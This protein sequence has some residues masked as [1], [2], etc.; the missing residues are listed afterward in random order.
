MPGPTGYI[1][2][3]Q[4][5]DDIMRQNESPVFRSVARAAVD[6]GRGQMRLLHEHVRR[7]AGSDLHM[8]QAIGDCVAFGAAKAVMTRFAVEGKWLG[9]IATESVYGFSRVEVGKRKLGHG[10][11][12]IGLWAV[13]AM[14]RF[15]VLFRER[16]DRFDLTTYN[17]RRAREWGWSGVPDDLEDEA[18]D[19]LV[20]DFAQLSGWTDLRDA[21]WN[22]WP[23][24]V[25]SDWLP[26]VRDRDG[27]AK[28]DGAGGHCEA[29]TGMND[30]GGRIGALV[31][32]SWGT[33]QGHAGS[34]TFPTQPTGAMPKRS[35][36]A[37]SV[38]MIVTA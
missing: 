2:D 28:K 30:A 10:D 22:G 31:D 35:T 3:P 27:F 9:E 20:V 25:C 19:V 14:N 5:R 8:V 12:S 26:G 23:C 33:F 32:G 36:A 24:F 17:G 38:T 11:G 18:D 1:Y 21:I 7:V 6:S 34:M 15:G 16:Y 13:E 29:V 4:A 37:S